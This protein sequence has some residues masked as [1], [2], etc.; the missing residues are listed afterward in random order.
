MTRRAAP[1]VSYGTRPWAER[2]EL[3][4]TGVVRP[5]NNFRNFMFPFSSA[6]EASLFLNFHLIF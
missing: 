2:K 1:C 5:P 6:L 4:T 3:S